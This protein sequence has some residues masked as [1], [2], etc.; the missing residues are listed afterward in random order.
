MLAP[1]W[2]IVFSVI[3]GI[4][5]CSLCMGIVI[6]CACRRRHAAVPQ[7]AIIYQQVL[8]QGT[9]PHG[10][11]VYAPGTTIYY[12]N[13]NTPL[14]QQGQPQAYYVQPQ[15]QQPQQYPQAIPNAYQPPNQM[16]HTPTGTSPSPP[17]FP[18][19]ANTTSMPQAPS[20]KPPQQTGSIN[21]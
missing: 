7:G 15:H 14:L 17:S 11:Q 21:Q 6:F 19:P 10:T 8:P 9:S 13:P 2:V 5:L 18:P 12:T 20:Y 16:Y 3:G 4:L 1:V